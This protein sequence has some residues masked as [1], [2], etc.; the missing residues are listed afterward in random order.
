MSVILIRRLLFTQ[1]VVQDDAGAIFWIATQSLRREKKA[2]LGSLDTQSRYNT[3][4][5]SEYP[6]RLVGAC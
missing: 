3:L 2:E 5:R 6:G 1:S 4:A